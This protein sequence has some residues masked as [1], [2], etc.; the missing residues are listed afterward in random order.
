MDRKLFI[1]QCSKLC[2]AAF[3]PSMLLS[4]CATP[5]FVKGELQ[6]NKL[7]IPI[8]SFQFID[9]GKAKQREYIIAYHNELNF[10]ILVTNLP[11]Y[12]A[13]LMQCSHQG[14]EL[15]MHGDILVCPA[16]GSEFDT[17]GTVIEG[18]ATLPLRTFE[19]KLIGTNLNIILL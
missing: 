1:N 7:V 12:K 18:P 16:H 11:K 14:A 17:Q 6:D 10:P 4:A 9:K 5:G 13:F 19:V 3:L 15:Q 8:D 2:I